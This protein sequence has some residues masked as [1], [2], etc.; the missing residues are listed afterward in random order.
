M[1]GGADMS[2]PSEVTSSDIGGCLR[3]SFSD[4]L[5]HIWSFDVMDDL[6]LSG[7]RAQASK[8]L[9]A[10]LATTKSAKS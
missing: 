3:A 8:A 10:L 4:G 1:T 2:M 7:Y 5:L 9:W 6:D